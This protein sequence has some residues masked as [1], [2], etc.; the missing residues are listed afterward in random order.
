MDIQNGLS[1][2]ITTRLI[3][4]NQL[5][6]N[7]HRRLVENLEIEIHA[8][9]T[10]LFQ[11]GDVDD[12]VYYLLSGKINMMATDQSSFIID[13]NVDHAFYPIGQ[14]QP[15]QYSA[16]VLNEAQVLK[17]R[18]SLFNSLFE[19]DRD[20]T[21]AET[22]NSDPDT[23]NDWMTQL[24]ESRIFANI[25]PQNIQKIFE[26]F[27]EVSINRNDRI[28]SQ[29]DAGDYFY[30]IKHG[31]FEVIRRLEKQKK[32]YR[33]AVLHAG[34]SF[35]EESLLGNVPR[36]AS[37]IAK[38]DGTLMR[39]AKESF[40]TLIRDPVIRSINFDE[41]RHRVETGSIWLDVRSQSEFRKNGLTGSLNYPLNTLRIQINKLD[42]GSEYVVYCDDGSKSSIAA[43]LLISRGFTVRHLQGGIMKRQE[44]GSMPEEISDTGG[45]SSYASSEYK[46]AGVSTA[47]NHELHTIET[48]I[49]KLFSRQIEKDELTT[50]LSAVLTSV[51]KQLEKAY[52]EKNEA[53]V[54]RFR[55][56]HELEAL[57]L[58]L[59]KSSMPM[60]YFGNLDS[61][62]RSGKTQTIV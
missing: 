54:A 33:L 38:T 3:P 16:L 30:I 53:E 20:D 34:E 27:Q 37:V 51:F 50:A 39:V 28:I 15:R 12:Y 9:G 22:A 7:S 6:G 32:T 1:E 41:A 46:I 10:Y 23:S 19:E 40:L 29:G 59:S 42:P 18:K 11:Q 35:G 25:P 8:V 36:N 5:S 62:Y 57:K 44:H 61:L 48:L 17:I 52:A 47:G 31:E 58:L 24:L 49:G 2:Y 56:E 14:M 4:I 21:S 26:L 13:M 45:Q 55:A 60:E 43:Y